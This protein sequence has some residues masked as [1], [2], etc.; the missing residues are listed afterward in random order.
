MSNKA[1]PK[2]WCDSVGCMLTHSLLLGTQQRASQTTWCLNVPH[3]V[4]GVTAADSASAPASSLHHLRAEQRQDRNTHT[5]ALLVSALPHYGTPG[6]INRA[7]HWCPCARHLVMC[8]N[9]DTDAKLCQA[10]S[11]QLGA[12]GRF[13]K[14][15]FCDITKC[16]FSFFFSL[17]YRVTPT[18]DL[19]ILYRLCHV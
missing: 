5:Q 14:A 6:G 13:V 1:S 9:A 11:Y 16:F 17:S 7:T 19:C 8:A 4:N 12:T 18:T 2:V 15:Y 10:V 3:S